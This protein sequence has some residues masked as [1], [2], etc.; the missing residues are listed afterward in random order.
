[1]ESYENEI[2]ECTEALSKDPSGASQL[3]VRRAKAYESLGHNDLAYADIRTAVQ[4]DPRNLDAVD[5]AQR[6][7]RL[8]LTPADSASSPNTIATTKDSAEAER[9]SRMQASLR[10]VSDGD[11]AAI[12]SFVRS[13]AFVDVLR[14]CDLET[15]TPDERTLALA[16]LSR[17]FNHPRAQESSSSSNSPSGSTYP[18]DLIK[19]TCAAHFVTVLDSTSK[20]DKTLAFSALSAIFQTS[21]SVGA[22]ILNRTSILEEVADCLEYE[23]VDVQVAVADVLA[24]ACSDRTCRKNVAVYC[25]EYLARVV[26]K[27]DADERLK[28]AAGVAITK[29]TMVEDEDELGR[30]A[31]AQEAGNGDPGDLAADMMKLQLKDDK[32]ADL[33]RDLIKNPKSERATLLN[34]VEGLAYSSLNASIK[35]KITADLAFLKSLFTLAQQPDTASNSPL[36]YGIATILANV[37]MYRPA[38]T[39]E[40]KQ[41]KRLRD[42]AN[43]KNAS[44]NPGGKL[45][46]PDISADPRDDEPAVSSRCVAL[47]KHGAVSALVSLAKAASDNTRFLV[48]Q[49]LLHLAT[50]QE[51]RGTIVQQG[52]ARLLLALSL[53]GDKETVACAA[54]ALAKIAITMDPRV[55]FQPSQRLEL[56]RP[57]LALARGEHQLR[58]FESLMALTNLVSVDEDVRNRVHRE[59]G[60]TAIENAQFSDNIMIR[61]AATEALCNMMFCEPVYEMYA[62]PGEGAPQNRIKLLLALS[63]VEDFQTRRAA[64][65][66]LAILAASPGAC[67][68]IVKEP[69]GLDVVVGLVSDEEKVEIQHRGVEIMRCL[70]EFG[71]KEMGDKLVE[72]GTHVRLAALVKDCE[73]MEIKG[74]AM[75]TLKVMAA[76]GVKM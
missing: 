41:L 59:G 68:M 63:D 12:A 62:T 74:V 7:V 52:G 64:S 17:L 67:G 1:M 16:I 76:S 15:A 26:S 53:H 22:S 33:F 72:M 44:K 25:G 19:Q 57:L 9:L 49:S 2:K 56:V 34:A 40:Q 45:P 39:D 60:M 48:V 75:E 71:G 73:V 20:R 23:S 32:L 47:V 3:L 69:R 30:Q 35:E 18:T 61:R 11:D 6:L 8:V 21:V 43:A 38:L 31:G 55:A 58:V 14:A 5:A 4:L 28:V 29:M 13:T 10:T 27:K 50:P 65:G 42:L 46:A 70:V 54:Q 51:T 24:L 66:A 37:T 36:T